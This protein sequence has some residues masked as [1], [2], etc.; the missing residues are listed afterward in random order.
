MLLPF[1]SYCRARYTATLFLPIYTGPA[2]ETVV[3][4][5]YCTRAQWSCYHSFF[6]NP[7]IAVSPHNW[8]GSGVRMKSW[9]IVSDLIKGCTGAFVPLETLK[10]TNLS[11]TPRACMPA[12]TLTNATR[13]IVWELCKDIINRNQKSTESQAYRTFKLTCW[14]DFRDLQDSSQEVSSSAAD[15]YVANRVL[16]MRCALCPR[17][18]CIYRTI[19]FFALPFHTSI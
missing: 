9:S 19:T 15:F 6:S 3:H 7:K 11:S 13:E 17:F 4:M 1:S 2:A 14:G 5:K 12:E 10:F 16:S 8:L 18:V